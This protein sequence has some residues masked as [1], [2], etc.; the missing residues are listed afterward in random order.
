M[1]NDPDLDSSSSGGAPLNYRDRK[2]NAKKDELSAFGYEALFFQADSMAEAIE[3][4]QWLITWQGEDPS[5]EYALWLDRYDVRNLLDDQRLYTGPREIYGDQFLKEPSEFNEERFEDLDS[6]EELLFDMDEDERKDYLDRKQDQREGSSY[7]GVHYDY[8]Y[9]GNQDEEVL[10]P[11]FN[12]HFDVPEGMAAPENEKT[13]AL[14]ERTAKFVNSSSEPTMEII[15]QAKQATN[16]NF[17][18]LSKRH[19][20]FLFYKHVRWLMQTGLYES[21]EE[22][23]QREEEEARAEQEELD[24]K[25]AALVEKERSILHVD[26]EKVIEKTIEFLKAFQ[27]DPVYEKKLLSIMDTRFEFMRPGH[28][29][30]DYYTSRRREIFDSQEVHSGSSNHL[31]VEAAQRISNMETEVSGLAI[32][33]TGELPAG[34]I[35][36]ATT[37]TAFV[38]GNESTSSQAVGGE[39]SKASS[40]SS[41]GSSGSRADEMRRLDRLQRIKELFQQKQRKYS[42]EAVVVVEQQL[43]QLQEQEDGAT[44]DVDM[45]DAR[46]SR[47]NR[48]RSTSRT[49]SRSPPSSQSRSQSPESSLRKRTRLQSDE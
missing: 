41:S 8:D 7:K 6:D 24:R 23:Q 27:H 39:S 18:F 29:W 17:A 44:A 11:T 9:D 4:G 42:D 22:F 30:Y 25:A 13:L 28:I 40:S 2:A 32:E 45:T 49:G 3:Q 36:E 47:S 38:S 10:E 20:L 34:N 16:P 1:W 19:H 31:V 48:S 46:P 5:S 26:L 12:L 33:I 15:L 21:A 37:T 35:V 14:I 43:E